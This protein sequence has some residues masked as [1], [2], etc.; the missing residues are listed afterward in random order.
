MHLQTALRSQLDKGRK[1]NS[2]FASPSIRCPTP[3]QKGSAERNHEMIR[4]V[5][6]KGSSLDR[7]TQKDISLMMNHINSYSRKSIGDQCP[8]E[9]FSYFYGEEILHLLGCE[10]IVPND[11]T[12]NASLFEGRRL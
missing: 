4:Y 1:N 5:I 7:F 3:Y 11:V 9:L 12:L 8:Y 10:R 2:L 6:P